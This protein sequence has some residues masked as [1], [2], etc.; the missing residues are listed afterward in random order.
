MKDETSNIKTKYD[1]IAQYVLFRDIIVQAGGVAYQLDYENQVYRF[2]EGDIEHFTGYTAEELTPTLFESLIELIIPLDPNRQAFRSEL[3]RQIGGENAMLYRVDYNIKTKDGRS[4]WVTDSA[5][6]FRDE[7]N[8][9]I[10]TIGVLL[11]ITERKKS[12]DELRKNEQKFFTLF[13]SLPIGEVYVEEDSLFFNKKISEII[14]YNNSE[15]PSIKKWFSILFEDQASKYYEMYKTEKQPYFPTSR[16][17]PIRRKDGETRLVEFSSYLHNNI[18]IWLLNDVTEKK[19]AEEEVLIL[20]EL[21][22]I[23]PAAITVHD[24]DGNFLYANQKTFEMHGYTRE[25]YLAKNLREIDVPESERLI[26]SRIKMLQEVGEASFEV[27]HFRKDGSILPLEVFVKIIKWKE[28]PAILSVASDITERKRA[29]EMDRRLQ[30]V[31]KM[32]AIGRLAGGIAHDFNNILT[33]IKGSISLA[34]FNMNENDLLYDRL[35][36]IEEASE[37]AE[38]L[39]R[40]LLT[41]SRKQIENLSP[42]DINTLIKDVKDMLMRIIGEDISLDINL[43]DNPCIVNIDPGQLSQIIINL[44]VNSRDAMP[45]GGKLIIE[46][47][48]LTLDES[49]CKKHANVAPGEYVMLAVS[50]TGIGMSDELKRHIFEPFLRQER[51]NWNWSRSF[52]GLRDSTTKQRGY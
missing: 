3:S 30:Q 6:Q 17:L 10:S 5:M 32:E 44:S 41:F 47:K 12:E 8:N 52:H 33:I 27:A 19:L 48:C 35:K 11:D 21:L 43:S 7:N 29:E 15:I 22:D 45:N 42:T 20:S 26:E 46:T 24:F 25:E 49:Y 38:T 16:I 34:M 28:K 36:T 13:D 40:Q 23:A 51:W 14:G 1:L 50:D 2:I 4:L 18:E 31:S 9:L 39:T 37:R